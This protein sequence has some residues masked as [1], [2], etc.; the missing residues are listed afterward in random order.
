MKKLIVD[1]KNDGKKLYDFLVDKLDSLT[2]SLFCNTLRKKDIK[3]NDKRTNKNIVVYQDDVVLVYIADDLLSSKKISFETVYEDDN[4]LVL[5]KPRGIEITGAN[6]VTSYVHEKYASSEFLPMPCHRLDRNTCGLVLFA[7]TETALNILL[8]KFKNHE[9]E[10]HYYAWVAS[11]PKLKKQS[12]T[13]YLFKDNKKSLVYI[14]DVPKKGY[15]KIVTSY[16]VIEEKAD[17]TCFLDVVIE[18]GRTHQIR[19]HLA[20]IGLPIIGDGKYGKNEINKA[21]NQKMQTLCAYKLKFCF[22]SDSG[23][24]EYLNNK[25]F[26]IDT[27]HCF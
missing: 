2:Y 13:A 7:K 21:F 24:L 20:H 8:E 11:V 9:I 25:S 1:K 22:S 14:S 18:T 15:R 19:A 23:I 3:V 10:K 5:N 17:G 27:L 12:L 6:S 26:C 4:I 16:E